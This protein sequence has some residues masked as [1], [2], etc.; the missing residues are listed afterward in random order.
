MAL[1]ASLVTGLA[2]TRS[3]L[4]LPEGV[5]GPQVHPGLAAEMSCYWF[6][7][8]SGCHYRKQQLQLMAGKQAGHFVFPEHHRADL[9]LPFSSSFPPPPFPP[10]PPP[11]FPSPLPSPSPSFTSCLISYFPITVIKTQQT[12]Q[13]IKESIYFGLWLR[14]IRTGDPVVKDPMLRHSHEAENTLGIP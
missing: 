7:I 2:G 13:L 5:H 14:R 3:P 11:P 4:G 1:A 12:R 6:V 9:L 10:F 8:P